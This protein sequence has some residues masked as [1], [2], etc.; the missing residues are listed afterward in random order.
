MV[1]T[2][3]FQ[4]G[5][6]ANTVDTGFTSEYNKLV[7]K[8]GN[9]QQGNI[10]YHKAL[11]FSDVGIPTSNDD[12][13]TNKYLRQFHQTRIFV[14][15]FGNMNAHGKSDESNKEQ[16]YLISANLPESLSYKVGSNWSAPF[17]TFQ[18]EGIPNAIMQFAGNKVDSRADPLFQP[19]DLS[20]GI[21][22]LATMKVWNGSE[23]L[24]LNLSIPVIDD[25]HGPSQEQTG[26]N[27]NFV[28]ALEFLGSLCLPKKSGRLGFYVPPPSPVN[29]NFKYGKSGKDSINFQSTYGR[30][31][32][33]L[34]GMLLVDHCIITGLSVRY[35]DTKT[36]IRHWYDPSTMG[37]VG[38]T[39]TDYLAPLLAILEIQVTTV[40]AMTA[41]YFSNM[42]WLKQDKPDENGNPTGMGS[43]LVDAYEGVQTLKK[44][45]STIWDKLTNTKEAQ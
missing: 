44:V 26:V 2:S 20:S 45:G 41:D 43:G 30:I 12:S 16:T 35:P 37:Q 32:L 5:T 9:G 6:K 23:P 31:M 21:N 29:L 38:D 22:R 27:T 14:Q 42:L 39:G 13:T 3:A 11:D 1:N 36:M 40:E 7:G 8:Q 19:G 18:G 17:S 25:G 10:H 33:Q 4:V 34:G 15:G 28:E 24:S